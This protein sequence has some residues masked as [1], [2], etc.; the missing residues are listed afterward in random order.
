MGHK[1]GIHVGFTHTT[2]DEL[3]VLCAEIDDEH[4]TFRHR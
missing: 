3:G 1:L 2:R 4:W